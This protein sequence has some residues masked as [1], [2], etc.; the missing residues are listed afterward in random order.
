MSETIAEKA[1]L[2]RLQSGDSDAFAEVVRRYGG[3]LLASTRRLLGSEED[4]RDCV[5]DTF[6]KAL[7]SI[8]SFEGRASVGTWLHRIA[9]NVALSKLRARTKGSVE[10]PL[11]SAGNFHSSGCRIES[12]VSDGFEVEKLV[13]LREIKDIVDV[14]VAELPPGYREV[15]LLRELEG[16]TTQE[17]ADA[18]GISAAN[19]KVRFHRARNELK[20]KLMEHLK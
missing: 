18:L 17:A 11:S 7:S 14:F 19:V 10:E 4:A 1:L 15:Y 6:V 12:N 2:V 20:A 13:Q 5:Q 3:R 9:I 16:F 8:E